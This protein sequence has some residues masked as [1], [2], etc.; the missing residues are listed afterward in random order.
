MP[1]IHKGLAG[2]VADVTAMGLSAGPATSPVTPGVTYINITRADVDKGT[3]VLAGAAS[4]G[5]DPAAVVVIGD[6]HNDLPMLAGRSF[7]AS[8]FDRERGVALVSRAFARRVMDDESP[9]GHRLRVLSPGGPAA[10]GD[11]HAWLE[12]VGVVDELFADDNRRFRYPFTNCTQCG[13]RYSIIEAMPY[14]R[15]DTSMTGFH[16]CRDCRSEY[17]SPDS[18]RFHAQTNA[19]GRCGPQVWATDG[20]GGSAGSGSEAIRS[21]NAATI[22]APVMSGKR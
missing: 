19:C 3:A 21:P 1:D 10:G 5:I 18:R 13:P 7:A 4:L 6:G 15:A 16:F 17:E 22:S 11:D 14:E 8:D 12:I 9:V 2:V 20:K